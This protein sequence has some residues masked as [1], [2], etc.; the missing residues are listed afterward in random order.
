M[1]EKGNG[2]NAHWWSRLKGANTLDPYLRIAEKLGIHTPRKIDES[3][4]YDV[5]VSIIHVRDRIAEHL[6]R[7]DLSLESYISDSDL[8]PLVSRNDYS[9]KWHDRQTIIK[10]Y[11]SMV[12][13]TKHILSTPHASRVRHVR[14]QENYEQDDDWHSLSPIL[15]SR[16]ASTKPA[17]SWSED[18]DGPR[19]KTRS[20][21]RHRDVSPKTSRRDELPMNGRYY[22]DSDALNEPSLLESVSEIDVES[23]DELRKRYDAW[24]E[25]NNVDNPWARSIDHLD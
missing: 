4:E 10:D 15:P 24:C 13:S 18:C 8:L 9:V 20:I 11:S 5:D 14:I 19:M 7:N 21:L 25:K 22:D 6:A 12:S 2:S 1:D 3:F 16:D 17:I 23:D